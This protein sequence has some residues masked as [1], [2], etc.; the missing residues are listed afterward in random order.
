MVPKEAEKLEAPSF[1]KEG[2]IRGSDIKLKK[3][4]ERAD[5]K[6]TVASSINAPT[7]L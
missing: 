5:S 3:R 6:Q 2:K 4:L 1:A 7:T